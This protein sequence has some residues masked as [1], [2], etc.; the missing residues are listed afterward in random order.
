VFT[1]KYVLHLVVN[2]FIRMVSYIK[3]NH[4]KTAKGKAE[5]LLW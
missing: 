2:G 3:Q 1:R 4:V 5:E